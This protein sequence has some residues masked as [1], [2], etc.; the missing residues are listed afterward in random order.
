MC[1]HVFLLST[2]KVQVQ[3]MKL[4]DAILSKRV[5]AFNMGCQTQKFADLLTNMN[6]P[7]W[8]CRCLEGGGGRET[9]WWID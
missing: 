5:Y 8:P 9:R 3:Y 1:V 2:A 7:S 6:T 4:L